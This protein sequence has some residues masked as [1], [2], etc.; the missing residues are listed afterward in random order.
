VSKFPVDSD[1]DYAEYN[2]GRLY[3]DDKQIKK[4]IELYRKAD[5]GQ[6]KDK[7]D[8]ALKRIGAE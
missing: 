1:I 2:L 3:E 8:L 5:K 4:A 7:A 6:W